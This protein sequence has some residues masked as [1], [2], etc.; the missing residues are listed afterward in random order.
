MMQKLDCWM[1]GHID[2]INLCYFFNFKVKTRGNVSPVAEISVHLNRG[3]S[4]C[5]QKFCY[6]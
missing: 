1:C 6:R 4:V 2:R 5:G 3:G